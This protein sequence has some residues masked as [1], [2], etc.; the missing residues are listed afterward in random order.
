MKDIGLLFNVS[1]ADREHPVRYPS[2][3]NDTRHART[4]PPLDEERRETWEVRSPSELEQ[5]IARFVDDYTHRRLHEAVENVTPAVVYDGRRWPF[6]TT[7]GLERVAVRLEEVPTAFLDETFRPR[8]VVR[9]KRLSVLGDVDPLNGD[10]WRVPD[11]PQELV[12]VLL[13]RLRAKDTVDPC[14]VRVQIIVERACPEEMA[15]ERPRLHDFPGQ[16]VFYETFDDSLGPDVVA[17][18]PVKAFLLRDTHDLAEL[19]DERRVTERV[20]EGVLVF[21]IPF[22]PASRDTGIDAHPDSGQRGS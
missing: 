10:V 22:G 11:R 21:E 9:L 12:E 2:R 15:Q 4:L 19:I 17:E 13:Q 7:L 5:A 8:R 1:G 16:S 14:R 3:S 20:E 18:P 6:S